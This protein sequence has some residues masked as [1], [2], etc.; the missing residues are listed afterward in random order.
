MALLAILCRKRYL[1]TTRRRATL[2]PFV[3]DLDGEMIGVNQPLMVDDGP[4]PGGAVYSDPFTD[5]SRPITQSRSLSLATGLGS[6]PR[7]ESN[8]SYQAVVGQDSTRAPSPDLTVGQAAEYH[9]QRQSTNQLSLPSQPPPQPSPSD[10]T[11]SRSPQTL[12]PVQTQF[13]LKSPPHPSSPP[14][15]AGA[16]A[17][18]R[19]ADQTTGRGPPSPSSQYSAGDAEDLR[20]TSAFSVASEPSPRYST[21]VPPF[22]IDEMLRTT[23]DPIKASSS[24]RPPFDRRQSLTPTVGGPAY[25]PGDTLVIAPRDTPTQSPTNPGSASTLSPSTIRPG[26]FGSRPSPIPEVVEM[27]AHSQDGSNDSETWISTRSED[28]SRSSPV[29]MTAERVQLTPMVRSVTSLVSPI[30]TPSPGPPTSN[31]YGEFVPPT[32]ATNDFPQ[33]SP[34]LDDSPLLPTLLPVQP[35]TL[36]KKRPFQS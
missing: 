31:Y 21:H 5:D 20:L 12:P 36:G 28:T 24:Y 32:G 30:Y 25:E 35:L 13:S 7:A 17:Y 9:N 34:A 6:G 18:I 3:D 19:Y 11:R 23:P 29:V 22:D 10:I 26:N 14:F 4:S 33:L 15:D 27:S 2:D 1:K 8:D 16:I